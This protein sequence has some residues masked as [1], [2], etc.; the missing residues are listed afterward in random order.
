MTILFETALSWVKQGFSVLPI[1]Y[2]SK[3]PAIK[4]WEPYQTKLPTEFE[5]LQWFPS[6]MR[7]I[8][9]IISNGLVVIDFDVMDV[10]YYW[11]N[12]FPIVTYM[13]KTRRGVHVYVHTEQATKNFH[14]NLL[15]IKAKRGYVLIPPSIHPSGYQ[16][17]VF[18]N[19][20]IMRID[21]LEDILPASF[22]PEPEKI[23]KIVIAQYE[24]RGGG[25]SDPWAIADAAIDNDLE[26]GV[27]QKIKERVSLLSIIGGRS[28]LRQMGVG[29]KHYVRFT[30]IILQAFG[31]IL[32]EVYVAAESATSKRWM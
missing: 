13:V 8:G 6:K 24:K 17:Q 21:K 5:L 31:S 22:T 15:D 1:G 9:L 14:S 28:N 11:H 20:P 26:M 12:L 3:K 27:V 7:N 25:N 29:I 32:F 4:K 19:S 16:Y 10:F 30:R 23:E 18:N 2:Y